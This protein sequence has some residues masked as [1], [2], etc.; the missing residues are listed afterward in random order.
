MDGVNASTVV[1]TAAIPTYCRNFIFLNCSTCS[2]FVG[3]FRFVAKIL[4][5]LL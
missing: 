4:Y 2:Y 1:A 3:F 5:N